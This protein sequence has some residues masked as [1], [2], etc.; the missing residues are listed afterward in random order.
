MKKILIVLIA[1]LL[2]STTAFAQEPEITAEKGQYLEVGSAEENV[3][4]NIHNEEDKPLWKNIEVENID[5]VA[6]VL[7]PLNNPLKTIHVHIVKGD[8]EN[9]LKVNLIEPHEHQGHYVEFIRPTET[10]AGNKPYFY[11]D[12]GKYFEDKTCTIEIT[13]P[14]DEWS[15]LAPIPK[16]EWGEGNPVPY[17]EEI[18]GKNTFDESKP[19]PSWS[20]EDVEVYY[21]EE[22]KQIEKELAERAAEPEKEEITETVEEPKAVTYSSTLEATP[23]DTQ[24]K[25]NITLWDRIKEFFI[26]LFR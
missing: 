20:Q 2:I 15:Y 1:T 14:I 3:T 21:K 25:E 12:C 7:I 22:E 23:A 17:V 16:E 11:C 8:K 24:P 9:V 13:E 18:D 26:G 19:N 10:E 4:V 5:G 6:N